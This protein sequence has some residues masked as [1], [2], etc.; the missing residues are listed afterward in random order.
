[1]VSFV[2]YS[3]IFVQFNAEDQQEQ[4]QNT[5][6]STSW[7]FKVNADHERVISYQLSNVSPCT[8]LTE[9]FLK[10]KIDNAK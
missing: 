10:K 6:D 1:M 8:E 3:Y 9:Y 2:A 4:P 5:R 7:D